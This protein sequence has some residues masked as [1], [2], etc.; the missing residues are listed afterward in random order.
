MSGPFHQVDGRYRLMDDG[1]FIQFLQLL[2]RN[3][4]HVILLFGVQ[5]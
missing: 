1:V 3:N 5:R 2:A 4:F